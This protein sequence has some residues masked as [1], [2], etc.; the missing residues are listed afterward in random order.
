MPE[1]CVFP[2]RKIAKEVQDR[3]RDVAPCS[4][5]SNVEFGGVEVRVDAR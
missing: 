5:E 2:A 3:L 4:L 1:A